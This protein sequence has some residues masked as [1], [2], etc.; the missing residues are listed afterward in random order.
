M[1]A[2]FWVGLGGILGSLIRWGLSAAF[3]DG[4]AGTLT[5]NLIG[6]ALA[7]FFLVLMER[8]GRPAIRHFLLPGFCAG[9]TTFSTFAFQS[10]KPTN[11]GFIY[12]IETLVLSL[13]VIALVIPLSRKIVPERR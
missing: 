10:I 6:V 4:R 2:V 3:H 8:H 13:L 12:F 1:V 11:G 9:L 5:A 7:G